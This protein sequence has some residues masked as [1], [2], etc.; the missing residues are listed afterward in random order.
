MSVSPFA[1]LFQSSA[2]PKNNKMGCKVLFQFE[3]PSYCSF[4][5]GWQPWL[6]LEQGRDTK[7]GVHWCCADSLAIDKLAIPESFSEV[8]LVDGLGQEIRLNSKRCES[9]LAR[10][11]LLHASV[12]DLQ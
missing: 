7:L 10:G 8:E 1:R 9:G 12:L 3:F 5:C 6:L 2:H 4:E 11:N